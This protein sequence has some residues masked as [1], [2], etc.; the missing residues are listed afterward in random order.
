MIFQDI[1]F[2]N[3]ILEYDFQRLTARVEVAATWP[4]FRLINLHIFLLFST[5]AEKQRYILGCCRRTWSMWCRRWKRP[6]P[7]LRSWTRGSSLRS[8]SS[9]W[10][11]VSTILG[12]RYTKKNLPGATLLYNRWWLRPLIGRSDLKDWPSLKSYF[13]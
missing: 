4:C 1:I 2:Q 12:V 9:G 11:L 3:D 13:T 8:S 6:T 7:F 5:S 10:C